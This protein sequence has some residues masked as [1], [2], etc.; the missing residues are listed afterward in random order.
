MYFDEC[1]MS[2]LA[3]FICNYYERE[4]AVVKY[5]CT[6]SH[7]VLPANNNIYYFKR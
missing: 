1:K 3:C 6:N 4:N 5:F 7:A 2:V